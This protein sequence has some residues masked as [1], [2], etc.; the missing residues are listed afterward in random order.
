M[1]TTIIAV[2]INLLATVLPWL[3][4]SIAPADLTTTAQVI[5]AIGTGAYIWYQ[6]STNLRQSRSNSDVSVAGIRKA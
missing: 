5:V 3:G 2:I 1:S 6:R 4:I